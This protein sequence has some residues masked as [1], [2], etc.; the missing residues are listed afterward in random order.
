MSALDK[1]AR[2]SAQ[3]RGLLKWHNQ[4]LLGFVGLLALGLGI[5]QIKTSLSLPFGSSESTQGTPDTTVTANKAD[6]EALRQRDTDGDGLSDYDEQYLYKTSAYL[7][8]SDSDGFDDKTEVTSGNDPLC[9]PNQ[10]CNKPSPSGTQ[11]VA[12]Q[13]PPDLNA[14]QI[15]ELLKKNGVSEVELTRYT[16]EQLVALYRELA[17]NSATPKST[18]GSSSTTLTPEQRDALSKLK[19]NELRQ[20]LIRGGADAQQLK[21]LD[22]ATLEALVKEMIATQ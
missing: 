20:F 9:P 22:D 11:P 8:D 5:W 18:A 17:G 21:S 2:P 3:D 6:D 14:A 16:D 4:L 15:R 12:E 19:G 13:T 1:R 10:E 7:K